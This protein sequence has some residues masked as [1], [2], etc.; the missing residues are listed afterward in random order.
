MTNVPDFREDTVIMPVL[1]EL[2][3]CLCEE[4]V[5]SGLPET[6]FCGIYP[7]GEVPFDHCVNCGQTKCGQAWVRLVTVYPSSA[8]PQQ[9]EGIDG[10]LC[11]SP[12]AFRVE[13]GIL[14]C[15][16]MPDQ[17]GNPPGV[18]EN[19]G[20][21]FLQMADMQAM[22]R[23]ME[24]CLGDSKRRHFVENYTPVTAGGCVGGIWTMVLP[25]GRY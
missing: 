20:A 12:L 19:Y 23:A 8:F 10:G 21:A 13:V 22:R 3:T 15:A 5:A 9:D 25:E 18:E 4:I 7:G 16:P 11:S 24:C 2:A 14:R 17:K 6:C 1:S